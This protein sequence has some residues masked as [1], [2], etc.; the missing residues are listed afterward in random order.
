MGIESFSPAR[1]QSPVKRRRQVRR[2]IN[3]ATLPCRYHEGTSHAFGVFARQT[4]C[5]QVAYIRLCRF[6][7]KA[8]ELGHESSEA[9]RM[10]A[11]GLIPCD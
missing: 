6:K 4:W 1:A 7:I 11:L 8:C 9:G 2:E 10:A 5:E 3:V